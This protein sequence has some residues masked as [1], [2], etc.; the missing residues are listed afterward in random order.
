VKRL[1]SPILILV[2]WEL[3]ARAG[4]VNPFLVPAPS[5]VLMTLGKLTWNLEL[6][7]SLYDSLRRII[8][9]FAIA[10]VIGVIVGILMARIQ[11][12][13]TALDPLVELIRPVSPLAIFP[14]AILWFGIG[15][16]SKIF[17]IALACA[18]P[19]ILNTYAGVR[20]IDVNF[21]RASRSL[22]ASQW[23]I[24]RRVILPACMPHVFTGLRL[25][26][27]IALIVIIAAEMI[28][29]SSGIGYM[30]LD[31]QQTFRVDRVFAGIVAIGVLGFLTDQGFRYLRRVAL[32]WY[33][34]LRD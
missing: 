12:V 15:E 8:A 18:F 21:I 31:A 24:L 5:T 28:G 14:L 22:G 1:I 11:A 7:V 23:E 27:G 34:E 20:T 29:G 33:R 10:V 13:E 4:W 30:I 25:A 16:S 2:V 9:G 26:W 32:P 6:F 17:L 19:V 3:I